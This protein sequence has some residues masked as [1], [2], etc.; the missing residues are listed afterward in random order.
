MLS[1]NLIAVA[2]ALGCSLAPPASAQDEPVRGEDFVRVP[3]IGD[4][5]CLSNAFQSHMV[6]QRDKPIAVWGW[7]TPGAEVV[8]EFAGQRAEGEAGA[9]RSWR[10]ELPAVPANRSPQKL[11]VGDGESTVILED[12]LVGDVWVLGGQSNM[13]FE[14]A[15]VDDGFLEIVSANFPELRLL[16]VPRGKGFGSVRSHQRLEEWSDWSKRHF[17]KGD[18]LVC[19]P[20]TVRDF[21]AIGYVF[22]RRLLMASG[23]PIGL[24]D[25]SVGGTTVE[26]WTPEASLSTIEGAETRAMLDDWREKIAAF[27]PHADLEQRIAN[28][29]RN[30]EARAER[31]DPLPAESA[32]PADLRPGPA[33]DR[34]RP[35]YCYAS[36]IRPFEGLAVAGALFHQGYNNCFDGSEGA[37]MYAQVFPHLIASWRSAF[38]DPQLPFCVISLCTAGEPQTWE[39]FAKPMYDVGPFIREAQHDAFRRLREAG[40]TAVG[41]V[42]TYDLRRSWYHPQ[43]KIPAGER[44]AKWALATRYG[45][46]TGRDAPLQWQPPTI[47]EVDRVEGAIRLTMSTEIKTADDSDGRML[48]FAI[49]GEDGKFYPAEISY[50]QDGVDDRNRPKLKRDTLVLS[51][52]FVAAPRHYR[53]AWARNPMANL[54]NR[55]GVP[56]ATQRSDDWILEEICAWLEV[57]DGMDAQGRR[58]WLGN[59]SRRELER[60]DTERRLAEAQAEIET[61]SESLAK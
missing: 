11:V 23:V 34:N 54:V 55:F 10:V 21:S 58:R 40:D 41:F 16:T 24:I 3:A 30:K 9:D 6:V 46:L 13:E 14:I 61:L 29:N 26:T 44:A 38:G 4:G 17:T 27:D 56:L 51:S 53:Y 2:C 49:A 32:P 59:N 25:A 36:M 35:G 12:V 52:P 8:V 33:A 39:N 15:K 48:G 18:W 1:R 5:L 45:L 28:Y 37:K 31:G 57:P 60:L 19:S 50:F 22:G 20:E 7:A 43:I 42:S 47:D